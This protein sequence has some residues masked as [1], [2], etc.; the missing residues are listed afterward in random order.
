MPAL[1]LEPKTATSSLATRYARALVMPEVAVRLPAVTV[2]ESGITR[3]PVGRVSGE[4]LY[5][6]EHFFFWM[7]VIENLPEYTFHR[8]L[9]YAH[10]NNA[11]ELAR[12]A[13]RLRLESV[14]PSDWYPSDNDV[15]ALFSRSGEFI[16]VRLSTHS[17]EPTPEGADCVASI[18]VS[19][20]S[21]EKMSLALLAAA[22]RWARDDKHTPISA[23]LAAVVLP[24]VEQMGT[25]AGSAVF[26]SDTDYGLAGLLEARH[27]LRSG[28]ATVSESDLEDLDDLI[29]THGE[30]YREYLGGREAYGLT[31]QV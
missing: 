19:P 3:L 31:V 7:T 6:S 20:D 13:G 2:M 10:P 26:M 27:A 28:P 25:F 5:E 9:S 14:E 16:G 24:V 1:A 17:G 12:L 30:R 8:A 11:E 18:W 4:R 23:E 29:S 21:L 15:Q 22:V